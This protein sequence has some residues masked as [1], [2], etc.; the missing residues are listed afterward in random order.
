MQQGSIFHTKK[1]PFLSTFFWCP[2]RSLESK[3]RSFKK[4]TNQGWWSPRASPCPALA[5][6]CYPSAFI[7]SLQSCYLSQSL[8]AEMLTVS[9]TLPEAAFAGHRNG[10][11]TDFVSQKPRPCQAPAGRWIKWIKQAPLPSLSLRSAKRCH[12]E[13]GWALSVFSFP[14]VPKFSATNS[15]FASQSNRPPCHH[16]VHLSCKKQSP[17]PRQAV[18]WQERA[19]VLCPCD[20]FMAAL[21]F[22]PANWKCHGTFNL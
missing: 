6:G 2:T 12:D 18:S 1:E 16:A 17:E 22:S 4:G 10:Y 9:L 21:L 3:I 5:G 19:A 14:L 11:F 13:L 8:R 15:L 20:V 7:F